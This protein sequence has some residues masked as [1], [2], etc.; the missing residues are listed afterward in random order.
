VQWRPGG[1]PR[2]RLLPSYR[3]S[4][5]QARGN[6]EYCPPHGVPHPRLALRLSPFRLFLLFPPSGQNSSTSDLAPFLWR[7]AFPACLATFGAALLA[8][9]PPQGDRMGIFS[10]ASSCWPILASA[11]PQLGDPLFTNSASRIV[12]SERSRRGA[13]SRVVETLAVEPRLDIRCADRNSQSGRQARGRS[14][15][16]TRA[17]RNA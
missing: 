15:D 2:P 7:H 16:A 13:G 17:S 10:C 1:R 12:G 5:R 14:N 4:S 3:I 8:P 9:F 11:R 6:R